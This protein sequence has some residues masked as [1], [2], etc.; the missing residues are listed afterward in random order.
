MV[1]AKIYV[2][3]VSAKITELKKVPQG[4]IGATIEVAYSGEWSQLKKTAV[5]SG[6]ATKDVLEVGNIITIPAEVVAKS[7]HRLRVG[8]YGV[9]DNTLAIPTLWVDLGTIQAGADP[10]GDVTTDPQLPVWAQLQTDIRDIYNILASGGGG[11]VD[12]TGYATETYVKQAIEAAFDEAKASGDFKGEPG[13]PGAPGAPGQDYVLTEADKQ[14][15]VADVLS[16]IPLA[17][18]VSY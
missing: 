15:I 2:D 12:L 18:G 7:G 14:E 17:E 9:L 16:A 6:S 8:F 5:F 1:I 4:I 13:E 3:G 10:S 11:Y